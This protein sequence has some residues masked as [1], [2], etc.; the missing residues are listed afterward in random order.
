MVKFKDFSRPLSVFQVLFK[1]KCIFNDF[2]K[3]VL[4]I[5][6]LFKP[7]QTLYSVQKGFVCFDSISPSQKFLNNVGMGPSAF[8]ITHFVC[9]FKVWVIIQQQPSNFC[10]TFFY[11][12]VQCCFSFLKRQ[13]K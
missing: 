12:P 6:V 9:Y 7:V 11:C 8:M 4:Y 5:Q 3:T 1:A 13:Y 10:V 2:F